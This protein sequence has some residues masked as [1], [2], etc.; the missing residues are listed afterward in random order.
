MPNGN[1]P[2]AYNSPI[3]TTGFAAESHQTVGFA[4]RLR[5]EPADPQSA[6]LGRNQV[7]DAVSP[8]IGLRRFQA[9]RFGQP[10]QSDDD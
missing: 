6:P 4:A 5:A 2:K 8:G 7:L 10:R 3:R 1:A 9:S